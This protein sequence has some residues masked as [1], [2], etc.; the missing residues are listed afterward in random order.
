[1]P[2]AFSLTEDATADLEAAVA[3]IARTNPDAAVKL[4]DSLEDAFFFLAEW[5]G[6]GHRRSDLTS[7]DDVRFWTVAPRLLAYIPARIP[8]LIIAVLHA[9][10]PMRGILQTRLEQR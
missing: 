5:P 7:V 2:A 1:M 6:L 4:A 8:I 3:L 10:Q 9:S